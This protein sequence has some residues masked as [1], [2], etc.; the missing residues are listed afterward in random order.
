MYEKNNKTSS[1]S[2]VTE[3]GNKFSSFKNIDPE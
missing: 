3:N 1:K 2:K